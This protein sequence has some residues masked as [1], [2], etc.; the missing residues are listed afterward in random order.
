MISLQSASECNHRATGYDAIMRFGTT[1]AAALTLSCCSVEPPRVPPASVPVV[2]LLAE[3]CGTGIGLPELNGFEVTCSDSPDG[4]GARY[5]PSPPDSIC[6]PFPAQAI[7]FGAVGSGLAFQRHAGWRVVSVE[8]QVQNGLALQLVT[9]QRADEERV[10][11]ELWVGRTVDGFIELGAS[12]LR[13]PL[14]ATQPGSVSRFS[15]MAESNALA[16]QLASAVA[17]SLAQT[18][19]GVRFITPEQGQQAP[20]VFLSRALVVGGVA[21]LQLAGDSSDQPVGL[22]IRGGSGKHSLD[23]ELDPVDASGTLTEVAVDP[24]TAQW[25]FTVEM[26]GGTDTLSL[27]SAAYDDDVLPTEPDPVDRSVCR[28]VP[29]HRS[30][31]GVTLGGCGAINTRNDGVAS[32]VVPLAGSGQVLDLEAQGVHSFQMTLATTPAS[33]VRVALRDESGAASSATLWVTEVAKPYEI[34]LSSFA[35]PWIAPSGPDGSGSAL[36]F[37]VLGAETERLEVHDALLVTALSPP[38]ADV[39]A[40]TTPVPPDQGPPHAEFGPGQANGV[41]FAGATG[42]PTIRPVLDSTHNCRETEGSVWLSFASGYQGAHALRVRARQL[43]PTYAGLRFSFDGNYGSNKAVEL[44]VNGG[45]GFNVYV[46]DGGRHLLD[47]QIHTEALG[48]GWT[49]FTYP[50]PS[51]V[52]GVRA[53]ELLY[54]WSEHDEVLRIDHIALVPTE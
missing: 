26:G 45:A 25:S 40:P 21:T 27:D 5:L 23:L 31:R 1:I 15:V 16:V 20:R 44:V 49:R 35:R 32:L 19:T 8:A 7:W 47:G 41:L 17:A 4:P 37:S 48:A 28:S 50:V 9:M 46:V 14:F 39:V 36:V 52:G 54:E 42:P 10:F 29:V 34:H 51:S 22:R 12:W 30:V 6:K 18:A 38:S 24:S 2:A 33:A 13:P 3:Q 43:P 53:I 11:T